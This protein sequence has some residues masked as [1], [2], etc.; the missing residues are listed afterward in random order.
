MVNLARQGV[1]GQDFHS[2]THSLGAQLD[3]LLV[4]R[5]FAF[6]SAPS[7][8]LVGSPAQAQDH[9]FGRKEDGMTLAPGVKFHLRVNLPLIFGKK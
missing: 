6:L 9:T 3:Q 4:N 1:G 5:A 2:G 8:G 7:L